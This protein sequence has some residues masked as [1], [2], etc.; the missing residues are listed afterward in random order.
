MSDGTPSPEQVAHVFARLTDDP[1][2]LLDRIFARDRSR[3]GRGFWPFAW[4]IGEPDPLDRAWWERRFGRFD[5]P[6]D[7]ALDA[8]WEENIKGCDY[9]PV[10]WAW[11]DFLSPF[12]GPYRWYSYP[13]DYDDF[14]F[15]VIATN[16]LA[17]AEVGKR[18][19]RGK[20]CPEDF[21][22]WDVE[23]LRILHVALVGLDRQ[24]TFEAATEELTYLLLWHRARWERERAPVSGNA[25]LS[26]LGLS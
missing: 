4:Y 24:L 2:V 9:G 22:E 11:D 26:A 16:T 15:E 10:S 21:E 6:L 8:L 25:R 3:H 20:L 23:E 17:L 5:P 19:L 13:G 14:R 7:P 12:L 18:D 1:K